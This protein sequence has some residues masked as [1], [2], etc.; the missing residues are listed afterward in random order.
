MKRAGFLV[1][2]ALVF[3]A[4][5]VLADENTDT[6]YGRIAGD[7]GVALGAGATIAARGPRAVVDLRL[8]YLDTAGLFVS[9]EDASV[10]GA[11]A[12][13]ERILAGGFEL[14]PLF[15]ARWLKGGEW[16]LPR[17]DLLLDSFGIE[18]GV[19]LS[20]SIGDGFASTVGLQAGL[21]L[22]FPILPKAKGPWVG[23]HGG[24][25][26]SDRALEGEPIIDAGDRSLFLSI[27]LAYHQILP[28]HLVD[29]GDR[30]QR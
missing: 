18:L 30:A 11:R 3:A 24:V 10:F 4:S 9:Y 14:R 17:L 15:L 21:G 7:L 13:P 6:S 26:W 16:A 27:T 8:R 5:P 28:V 23:F 1:G 29:F 22:E 19:A 2:A 20:Q 25:R 12:Q